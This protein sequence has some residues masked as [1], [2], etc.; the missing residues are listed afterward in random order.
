MEDGEQAHRSKDELA[1]KNRILEFAGNQVGETGERVFRGRNNRVILKNEG[2][3]LFH[4]VSRIG[5]RVEKGSFKQR[6]IGCD[7]H[8]KSAVHFVLLLSFY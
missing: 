3:V 8:L 7:E 6:A 2:L 5:G 1:C 4:I